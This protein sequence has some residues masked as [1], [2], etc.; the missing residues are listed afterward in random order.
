VVDDV[1]PVEEDVVPFNWTDVLKERD[2]DVITEPGNCSSS[3]ARAVLW[4]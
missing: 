2:I 3:F 4:R 1:L